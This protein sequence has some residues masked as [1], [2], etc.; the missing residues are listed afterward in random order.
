M[1]LEKAYRHLESAA[2]AKVTSVRSEARTCL[3]RG[4]LMEWAQGVLVMGAPMS[5][6][7]TDKKLPLEVVMEALGPVAGEG[8]VL[9]ERAWIGTLQC[10]APICGLG[11]SPPLTP[12]A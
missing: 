11:S 6:V 2:R 12:T 4:A 3:V 5:A 10:P 7:A 9:G 8:R 1:V